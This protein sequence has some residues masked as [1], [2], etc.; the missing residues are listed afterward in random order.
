MAGE[1]LIA[2]HPGAVRRVNLGGRPLPVETIRQIVGFFV[3]YMLIFSVIAVAAGVLENDFRVGLTGSIVTLGNI[4]PGYGSIGPM[5][6]FANLGVLTKLLFAIGMWIGRL[7]VMTVIVL[8]HPDVIR[9]IL[10]RRRPAAMELPG[11]EED[12]EP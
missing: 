1:I 8:F 12:E 10:V 4:G 3:A 5:E 6:T 9:T 2:L 11:P 7:E